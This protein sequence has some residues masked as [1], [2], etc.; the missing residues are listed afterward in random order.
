M[1]RRNAQ[2]VQEKDTLLRV[3]KVIVQLYVKFVVEK[4]MSIEERI[5]DE[6]D[7]ERHFFEIHHE[8]WVR[9]DGGAR[10]AHRV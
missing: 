1:K 2:L 7:F 6:M 5:D 3:F 4:V 9:V 8:A 10:E